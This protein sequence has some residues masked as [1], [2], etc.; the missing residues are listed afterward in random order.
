MVYLSLQVFGKLTITH[1]HASVAM[2]LAVALPERLFFDLVSAEEVEIVHELEVQG[3]RT[4]VL[5]YVPD[6]IVRFTGFSP[7]EAASIEQLRYNH[8]LLLPYLAFTVITPS[9]SVRKMPQTSSLVPLFPRQ[10][11]NVTSLVT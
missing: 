4:S 11:A 5:P 2:S 3:K 7:E 9:A 8:F 6:V 1:A 10:A